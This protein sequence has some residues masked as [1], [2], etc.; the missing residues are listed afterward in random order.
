MIYNIFFYSDVR[1]KRLNKQL[2]KLQKL[3]ILLILPYFI[4]LSLRHGYLETNTGVRYSF[5]EQKHIVFMTF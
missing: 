2:Q 1:N 4:A 3:K 5:H